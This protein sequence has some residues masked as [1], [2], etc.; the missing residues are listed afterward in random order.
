MAS[1]ADLSASPTA[2]RSLPCEVNI[3]RA[4]S[5]NPWM[6]GGR[7]CKAQEGLNLFLAARCWP[8]RYSGNF[9]GIHLRLSMGYDKSE[10]LNLVLAK[11][12]LVM[13]EINFVPPEPFQY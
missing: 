4:R 11:L 7:N 1:K 12:A 9:H 2:M 6:N 8:F 3:G 13:S 5:E 10:V